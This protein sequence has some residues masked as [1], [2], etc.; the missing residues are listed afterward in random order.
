[1]TGTNQTT[2]GEREMSVPI[3]KLVRISESHHALVLIIDRV[4]YLLADRIN[5]TTVGYD[6]NYLH[7]RAYDIAREAGVEVA[8]LIEDNNSVLDAAPALPDGPLRYYTASEA[9]E[10]GEAGWYRRVNGRW[11]GPALSL[12][13]ELKPTR[14]G[15]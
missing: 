9:P 6:R 14:R 3:L 13:A 11:S 15:E 4:E 10:A 12:E 7:G 5:G 1:M 8:G 2:E